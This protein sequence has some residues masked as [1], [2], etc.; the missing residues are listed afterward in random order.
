MNKFIRIQKKKIEIDKWCEGCSAHRDPGQLYILE[1][2]FK[3]AAWFRH[4]WENSLCQS[5]QLS[6]ECGYNVLKQCDKYI[7]E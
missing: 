6:D 3:N 2:I 1:W 4:A 5:C 7:E